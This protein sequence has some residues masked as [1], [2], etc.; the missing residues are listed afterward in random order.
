MKYNSRKKRAQHQPVPEP[1]SAASKLDIGHGALNLQQGNTR[2]PF[3]DDSNHVAYGWQQMATLPDF[4][5]LHTLIR[6]T[7]DDP[8]LSPE[9]RSQTWPASGHHRDVGQDEPSGFNSHPRR[10]QGPRRPP[11]LTGTQDQGEH[12]G[13]RRETS[14]PFVGL[15]SA[16][17]DAT[18]TESIDNGI[19][20]AAPV[21]SSRDVS[22]KLQIYKT[23]DSVRTSLELADGLPK[24]KPQH[25]AQRLRVDELENPQHAVRKT[26]H[27]SIML[28]EP[29]PLRI[30]EKTTNIGIPETLSRSRTL[31][32]AQMSRTNHQQSNAMHL[33]V[34]ADKWESDPPRSGAN[35][36]ADAVSSRSPEGVKVTVCEV[37]GLEDKEM[38]SLTT[39]ITE[40]QVSASDEKLNHEY[41]D[42][43]AVPQPLDLA[44]IR[45]AKEHKRKLTRPEVDSNIDSD[46]D[47]RSGS[48]PAKAESVQSC[49]TSMSLG[50]ETLNMPAGNENEHKGPGRKWYKGF[51]RSE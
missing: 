7:Q 2:T 6:G 38:D 22:Q 9:K 24:L 32:Q 5:G 21:L 48:H 51:R 49:A 35:Y 16:K 36:G 37:N 39:A 33:S 15:P 11:S 19:I 26:E 27:M 10:G 43:S 34:R 46:R 28:E 4:P 41:E 12:G 14:N 20:L 40:W 17:L 29:A 50:F 44:A 25:R 8:P 3:Y 31:E 42:H 45:T 23:K 30:R 1:S 47:N 18:S 13:G